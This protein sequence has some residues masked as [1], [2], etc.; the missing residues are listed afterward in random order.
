[1][2]NISVKDNKAFIENKGIIETK[3]EFWDLSFTNGNNDKQNIYI[4]IPFALLQK[5]ANCTHN[6]ILIFALNKTINYSSYIPNFIRDLC[7]FS[8]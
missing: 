5:N 2:L 8:I 3:H 1:M 4:S 6:G 7:L